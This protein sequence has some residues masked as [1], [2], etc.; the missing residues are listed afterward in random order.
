MNPE[1]HNP[2]I[3]FSPQLEFSLPGSTFQIPQIP[4]KN[5][6]ET[7]PQNG[8]NGGLNIPNNLPKITTVADTVNVSS[9]S[10]NER[11][12]SLKKQTKLEVPANIVTPQNLEIAQNNTIAFVRPENLSTIEGLPPQPKFSPAEPEQI[13]SVKLVENS[14]HSFSLPLP[15]F[16]L[17]IVAPLA[18]NQP[19][20][21]IEPPAKPSFV[22]AAENVQS[23]QPPIAKNVET[24]KQGAYTYS[25]PGNQ[26]LVSKPLPSQKI[27]PQVVKN[28]PPSSAPSKLEAIEDSKNNV[29]EFNLN[30]L[31][32]SKNGGVSGARKVQAEL[33]LLLS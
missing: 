3:G 28:N 2:T 12:S 17:E 9:L 18:L 23:F 31:K 15:T 24:D 27:A 26:Q 32:K 33:S 7:V 14:S 8:L 21:N 19:P 30:M 1:S 4:D 6:S 20:S 25:A 29:V 22:T 13:S 5:L 11:L 10:L 16:S